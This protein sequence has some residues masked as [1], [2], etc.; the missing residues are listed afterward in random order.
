M[1]ERILFAGMVSWTRTH[2]GTEENIIFSLLVIE[3]IHE[4]C[5]AFLEG[6]GTFK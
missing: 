3:G 5:G 6:I 1:W 2:G 4:I